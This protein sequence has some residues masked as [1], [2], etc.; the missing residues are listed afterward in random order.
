M[1]SVVLISAAGAA[2]ADS[3]MVRKA[4][5][6]EVTVSNPAMNMAPA[7]RK[8]C[9]GTDKSITD[10]VD[11]PMMKDCSVK[12]SSVTGT[13]AVIDASCDTPNKMRVATHTVITMVSSDAYHSET[14]A[15]YEGGAPGMPSDMKF[16][17]D[18]RRLGPCQPGETP[19]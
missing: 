11:N 17:N 8:I 9:F 6:W 5:E 15:H 10:V 19:R 1:L 18:A 3:A 2:P 14:S 13:S 7:P 16:T 12:L 4:G